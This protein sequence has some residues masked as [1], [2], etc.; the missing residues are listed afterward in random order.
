MGDL[1]L[2]G[3]QIGVVVILLGLG[4]GV[5]GYTERKHFKRLNARE[6]ECKGVLVSTLSSHPYADPTQ[7]GEMV[8]GECV[9]ATDYFKS[10]V[11]KLKKIIG[12][13]LR[14]YLSLMDR[15]R[16]EAV[17]RLVAAAQEQGYDAVC[18]VRF[19][20]ADVGGSSSMKKGSA[21][22]AIIASGTAYRRVAPTPSAS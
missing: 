7:G 15:S 10:F 22:V 2:F 4:F 18:N 6:I 5:G 20:S 21:M 3:I 13:E 14:A 9:I 8:I 11:T 16:R 19:V 1:I 17:L 12:G